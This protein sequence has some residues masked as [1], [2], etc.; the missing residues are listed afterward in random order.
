MKK[1]TLTA[2]AGAAVASLMASAAFAG[3]G[4][5]EPSADQLAS[6]QC[7]AQ[8]HAIGTKAF[9]ALYGKRAMQTCKRKGTPQA[10]GVLDNAAQQ[11]KA[12][13]ADP[14]FAAAH[15]G[16]TFDQ[17][18]GTNP[19]D[20]NAFGKCVSGKAQAAEAAQQTAVQNAAQACRAERADP[21]FATAHGGKSFSDFYGTNKN[22]RN[23]FGKCVSGKAKATPPPTS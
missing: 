1:I 8:Q 10:N 9:K 14:N 13:Q 19:N 16:A 23:A 18:Y 3:V 5:D 17:F 4:N 21:G 11:C 15:G 12:E 22:H 20:K 7:V 2:V 6:S